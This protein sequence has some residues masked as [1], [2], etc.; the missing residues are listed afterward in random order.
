MEVYHLNHN[1]LLIIIT[2]HKNLNQFSLQILQ[3]LK[4]THQAKV[5]QSL[6]ILHQI[7]NF[8]LLQSP[9]IFFS[10]CCI[11]SWPK[12]SRFVTV[13]RVCINGELRFLLHGA[14]LDQATNCIHFS[15]LQSPSVLKNL[16]RIHQNSTLPSQGTWNSNLMIWWIVIGVWKSV[17]CRMQWCA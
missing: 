14:V 15:N 13:E 1:K 7:T 10:N 5:N 16:V 17:Q 8:F 12:G 11:N 6:P 4:N 3:K 2:F 9:F